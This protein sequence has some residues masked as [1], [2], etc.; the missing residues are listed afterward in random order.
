MTT[1]IDSTSSSFGASGGG[2]LLLSVD[3][4]AIAQSAFDSAN[5][6]LQSLCAS[7][8]GT[9]VMVERRNRSLETKLN[10]LITTC[11]KISKKQVKQTQKL[12]FLQQQ[13][14]KQQPNDDTKLLEEDDDD[15]DDDDYNNEE[16]KNN[17]NND[18]NETITISSKKPPYTSLAELAERHRVRR[19]TLL[20]HSPLIELLELPSLMDA[21]VRTNLYDDAIQIAAFSNTLERRHGTATGI[22]S[23][24]TTG[25]GGGSGGSGNKTT[26]MNESQHHNNVVVQVIQQIRSRQIDLRRH[27]LPRLK[28][29]IS[30]PECLEI[31]TSLRRLDTIELEKATTTATTIPTTTDTKDST[32]TNISENQQNQKEKVQAMMEL[33][34]QIDF[35]EARDTW[36]DAVF[37]SGSV[38]E[39]TAAAT[40][41]AA[42]TIPSSQQPQENFF[43]TIER[44]RTRY[45]FLSKTF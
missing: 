42:S 32:T 3:E 7:H 45:V 38:I 36:I 25:I 17:D 10:E 23:A 14:Q 33:K 34:F 35:L 41:A 11:Q 39:I 4:R 22:T 37:V 27:L 16:E 1:T 30:M 29:N 31:V 26:M 5:E 2:G 13:Q 8:A 24:T 19:R 6:Q 43:D 21:C 44:Y 15:D 18:E 40:A 12:L 9:F 20:Q 28:A